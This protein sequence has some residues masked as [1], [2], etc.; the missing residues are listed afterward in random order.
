M[1]FHLTTPVAFFIFNRPNATLKVFEIIR[2]AKPQK[3]FVVADGARFSGE[4][5]KCK[6]ARSIIEKID[7]DCEVLTNFSDVNL[8]C[9]LRVSSCLDWV[10]DHV[11]SAIIL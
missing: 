1:D 5:S 2:D 7:W 10:F 11:E 8:G 3:L 6:E 9:K 4:E